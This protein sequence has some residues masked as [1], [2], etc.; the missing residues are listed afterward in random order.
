M[1]QDDLYRQLQ[2]PEYFKATATF[3][4]AY[5]CPSDPR[6][7]AGGT[8]QWHVFDDGLNLSLT[9]ELAMTSYQ[10]IRGKSGK[11]WPAMSFDQQG[12]F[13]WPDSDW[14]APATGVRMSQISDGL[15]NT[16]M[17]GERPP[18]PDNSAG[19]WYFADSLWT[20][21]EGPP[22]RWSFTDSKGNGKGTPCPA[23]AYFSPG[24]LTDYCHTSHFWSF[25]PGGGNWL[26]CDGSV[27]FM[28]YSAATI[29]IPAMATIAG[30]EEIPPLNDS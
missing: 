5:L 16:V 24:D 22:L 21:M 11:D 2:S 18:P 19:W 20:I 27:R 10:G 25:H 1:E 6:E 12:V 23:P 3:I 15:S 4:S 13:A 7:N 14:A 8:Y 26:L 9:L 17:V 30:G 29:V 28:P